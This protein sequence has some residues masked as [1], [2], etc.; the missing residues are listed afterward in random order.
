M[1]SVP[2]SEHP[3]IAA[4]VRARRPDVDGLRVLA[5]AVVFLVH[6]A[7]IFSPWQD[8]HVQNAERSVW[9]GELT[10]F[11]WPWVMPIFMLLGGAGAWF[12]LGK[13]TD[14]EYL[15]ERSLRLV[16]PGV[17]GT[18]LLIPPQIWI[19]RLAQGR[20]SGS[21]FSF[22]PHFVDGFYPE[23]NLSSGHLWFLA[24]LYLYAVLTLPLLRWLRTPSSRLWLDR[25]GRTLSTRWR[26]ILLPAALIAVTQIAL[27]SPF[28]QTLAL[29][30]DWANHAL[31]VLAYLYGFILM[32]HEGLEEKLHNVW[33]SALPFAL[34][35]SLWIFGEAWTL[36]EPP[37][38][39]QGYTARYV[40]FWG[41]Y[42]LAAWSW[43]VVLL[44]AARRFVRTRNPLLTWAAEGV[45][46][47]YVIHQTVIVL[48]A[49]PVVRGDGGLPW[50][51]SAIA[52]GSLI[53]TLVLVEGTKRW[54]P[55]RVLFG[56]RP[57]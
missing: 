6:C 9:L 16:L 51:F 33:V 42:S 28:P 18:F 55:T 25:L 38:L 27:R 19:E 4:V 52:T 21:F 47:F 49:Y 45:F 56:L 36:V 3:P 12:S 1:K 48:V 44:G 29:V 7:Q 13:R 35:G 57:H 54:T 14:M 24:Y 39:P 34:L 41:A 5:I 37:F 10:L 50:K 22:L 31:L 43:I 20:F 26:F 53:V 23:G 32:A 40:L 15:R 8:W 11:A 30:N 2:A 17:V 46:L